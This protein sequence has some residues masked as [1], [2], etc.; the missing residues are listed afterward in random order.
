MPAH[1]RILEEYG[2]AEAEGIAEVGWARAVELEPVLELE[3]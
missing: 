1:P 3:S 2:R